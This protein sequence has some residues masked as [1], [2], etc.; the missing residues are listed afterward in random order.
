MRAGTQD[1]DRFALLDSRR[2]PARSSR[3]EKQ[4]RPRL[5]GMGF[6]FSMPDLASTVGRISIM[7]KILL[8]LSLAALATPVLAEDRPT[9]KDAKDKVSYSIG[10]DIGGTFKKQKME[11]NSDA[12]AAGVK[13]ALAG[14]KPLLSDDEVKQVM[15]AFSKEMSEKQNQVNQEAGM[16]N[17]TEG[18]K[19]LTE[20]KGKPEVKTTASGLQYKVIKEGS[21]TPPKESDTVSVNYRGTLIDGTEFDSSYKRGQPAEFPVNRVI[22]GWTEALQ[23]MKPGSKYQLFIPSNLAYG[24]RGAGGE[25]GPSSVLLFDVELLSV[26]PAEAAASPAASPSVSPK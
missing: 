2:S 21:G 19:F 18:E 11:L 9:L 4:L 7:N 14:T 10:L 25:I 13:D 20:N 23:L 24:E 5:D 1:G 22:K 3:W 16:K 6:S 15:V 26:K 8:G 17:K 12:L